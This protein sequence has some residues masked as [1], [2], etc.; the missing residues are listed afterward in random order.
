M[1]MATTTAPG[2]TPDQ[3]PFR[4]PLGEE[5]A[6]SVIHGIG[7]AL[8]VAA[9][10]ILVTLAGLFGDAWRVVSFAVYG[11]SLILLYLAS[12]FYHSFQSPRL[13]RIFRFCDHAAIFILIAGS[14][15]PF[16]L[17]SIR[18]AWGWTVFGVIWGLAVIGIGVTAFVMNSSK[19]V[20]AIIYIAMGWLIVIALKPLAAALPAGGLFWL[21][22]G[23]VCYTAGTLF[24]MWRRLPY[25][26]AVWHVFVLGGSIFHFFA[27]LWYV[28]PM[29][30]A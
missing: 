5:I 18:G 8:S 17:V 12:T 4:Y 25:N 7:A 19:R 16:M 30:H 6:S 27:V 20:T 28:L 11:S 9:L 29:P 3:D 1:I 22:L 13:K 2:S 23:G 24:Y 15:T 21:S 26:H 14:Y 10:A